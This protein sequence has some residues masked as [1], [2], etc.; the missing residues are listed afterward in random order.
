MSTHH[1][2]LDIRRSTL[3]DKLCGA[4]QQKTMILMALNMSTTSSAEELR[5]ALEGQRHSELLMLFQC[6]NYVHMVTQPAATTM[7]ALRARVV[8]GLQQLMLE[9]RQ[10]VGS[11]VNVA[12]DAIWRWIGTATAEQLEVVLEHCVELQK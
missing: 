4:L 12:V 6:V 2:L 9:E 11:V 7:A 5:T 10:M 1:G 8:H 3:V